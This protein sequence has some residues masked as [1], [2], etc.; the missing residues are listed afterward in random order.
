M[1]N[2]EY[3]TERNLEIANDNV[4][5]ASTM[6]DFSSA[7]DVMEW[8]HLLAALKMA[9]SASG[10]QIKTEHEILSAAIEAVK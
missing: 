5:T 1:S 6:F 3:F 10:L 7:E 2:A 8:N 9:A 4:E